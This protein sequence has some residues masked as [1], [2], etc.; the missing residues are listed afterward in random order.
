MGDQ[1]WASNDVEGRVCLPAQLS[2]QGAPTLICPVSAI[3]QLQHRDI[4]TA[5]H[6]L[7]K[8]SI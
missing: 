7:L 6:T 4:Q 8:G 1:A 3:L 5:T 2:M